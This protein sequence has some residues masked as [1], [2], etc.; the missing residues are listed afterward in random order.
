MNF[1]V[2]KT[3][4]CFADSE[5]YEYILPVTGEKMLPYL[6]NWDI[7]I[8]RKLRRPT[9]IAQKGHIIIKCTLEGTVFRVSYPND[10]L[11]E[12]KT[13]FEQILRGLPCIE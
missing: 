1:K 4:N 11:R 8:N 9:V 6:E 10:F 12:H 2:I 3:E 13:K 7:R 5:T